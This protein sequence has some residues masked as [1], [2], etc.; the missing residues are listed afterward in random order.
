MMGTVEI[1]RAALAQSSLR[2]QT[3][4][5]MVPFTVRVDRQAEETS[6]VQ[7]H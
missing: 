2:H 3:E 6:C 7:A 1:S 5:G 4:G